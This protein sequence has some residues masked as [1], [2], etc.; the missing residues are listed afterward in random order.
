VNTEFVETANVAMV[1]PASTSTLGGTVAS[2]AAL[3]L[4]AIAASL[5]CVAT[6]V[7]VAIAASPLRTELG[8]M[9]SDARAAYWMRPV[10]AQ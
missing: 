10:G 9:L 4:N 3:L 8:A 7:T 2:V 1:E 5:F 6:R